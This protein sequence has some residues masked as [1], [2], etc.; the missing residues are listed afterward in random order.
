M[1]CGF[2][3]AYSSERFVCFRRSHCSCCRYQSLIMSMIVVVFAT[4]LAISIRMRLVLRIVSQR[5]RIPFEV[6]A[7]TIWRPV[8]FG[9]AAV[10]A[11]R[12]VVRLWHDYC[13]FPSV[14]VNKTEKQVLS[15]GSALSLQQQNTQYHTGNGRLNSQ[16]T[17][18]K[19]LAE[20]IL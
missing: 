18:G 11:V 10:F 15:K 8:Q 13:S 7:G 17:G 2:A 4:I 3:F 1:L 12:C 14:S 5:Y 16:T 9:P 19:G 20:Q 6:I